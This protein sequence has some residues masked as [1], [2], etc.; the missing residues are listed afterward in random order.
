MQFL[1]EVWEMAQFRRDDILLATQQHLYLVFI[2]MLLA[3][4]V[5]VPLGVIT[6]RLPRMEGIFMG[7]AGVMQ[8]IPSLALLALMI[9]LLGIGTPPAVAAMFLYALLPILRNTVTGIRGVDSSIKEAAAGMGMTDWQRLIQVELPIAFPVIMAGI[10]TALVM[11][12][13]VATLAG[14]IGGGGLGDLIVRGLSIVNDALIVVG[15][16]PA[17]LMA[18][19]ADFLMGRLERWLTPRGLRV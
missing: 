6:T 8:T 7:I 15:T 16:V 2:P 11:T 9:P 10:R 17:A 19:I 14:L 13:G 1:M 12:I 4:L 5:A 3:V 18:L